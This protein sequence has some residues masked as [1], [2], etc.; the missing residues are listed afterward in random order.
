M[1]ADFYDQLGVSQDATPEELRRSY[2]KCALKCHPDKGGSREEFQALQRAYEILNDPYKRKLY[3]QF[4]EEMVVLAEGNGSPEDALRAFSRISFKQRA[5]FVL[6]FLLV[7]SVF[8]LTP[9]FI[10]LRWDRTVTWPWVSCFIPL[11]ALHAVACVPVLMVPSPP[12]DPTE[13][14]R[15]EWEDAMAPQRVIRFL[16]GTV[17]SLLVLLEVFVALRL[18]GTISWSWYLVLSPWTVLEVLSIIRKLVLVTMESSGAIGWNLVRLAMTFTVAS[19]MNGS[20]E[21]WSVAFLPYIV[22]IVITCMFLKRQYESR[23]AAEPDMPTSQQSAI[24]G[25]CMLTVFAVWLALLLWRL[26]S[27]EDITAF[28]PLV[29][30]PYLVCC[31]LSCV[32]CAIDERAVQF[33]TNDDG[34]DFEEGLLN[35]QP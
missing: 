1:G 15:E 19:K 6:F 5:Q 3:D 18:D 2:K 17:M 33:D 29:V 12:E 34:N 30:P 9:I 10:A 28:I 26:M 21:D 14:Q 7:T 32:V 23:E 4:G 20:I 24:S 35:H 8:T 31:C 27:P 16:A 22:G 11:W 25:M 13:E